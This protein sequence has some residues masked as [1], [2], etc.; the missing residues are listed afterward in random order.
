[1]V[2]GSAQALAA[3]ALTIIAF[4]Q[5]RNDL[6]AQESFVAASD[7]AKEAAVTFKAS[8]EATKAQSA[9]IREAATEF[10][11]LQRKH[12]DSLRV[13][14]DLH[15]QSIDR[16]KEAIEEAV[17][18]VSQRAKLIADEVGDRF[19]RSVIREAIV[20]ADRVFSETCEIAPLSLQFYLEEAVSLEQQLNRRG[21]KLTSSQYIHLAQMGYAVLDEPLLNRYCES[22]I[23][24]S[25]TAM[26]RHL[27]NFVKGD[28]Y[29][30]LYA[31]DKG[32][33]DYL[34]TARLAFLES[35]KAL[36][37]KN[38][39]E[40][41]NY[42]Y[43]FVYTW[44]VGHEIA[45]RGE[46]TPDWCR[47]DLLERK[48]RASWSRTRWKAH[49]ITYLDEQIIADAKQGV[50]PHPRLP[51]SLGETSPVGP[52]GEPLLPVKCSPRRSERAPLSPMPDPA[53]RAPTPVPSQE[54]S[55]EHFVGRVILENHTTDPHEVCLNGLYYVLWPG[56]KEISAE[57]GDIVAY[58]PRY[59]APRKYTR[60]DWKQKDDHF[61]L[62]LPI[63]YPED[64]SK[65]MEA[66]GD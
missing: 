45:H 26:G 21:E 47:P 12:L 58:L 18:E 19:A 2:T 31:R 38:V 35:L 16:Q 6:D 33:A 8:A 9:A 64:V 56:R 24:E 37:D 43:G 42:L 15:I 11:A 51:S 60:K 65:F 27:A 1:M 13:Q 23:A 4:T 25:E 46:T 57:V 39:P 50:A 54:K 3:F 66:R 28:I 29:F 59:E 48:A 32:H 44:W 14:N 7:S 55:R 20:A 17:A 53:T 10:G 36:G 52:N 34:D 41:V 22:A 40:A 49:L 61:E 63:V 30:R 5:C 62:W